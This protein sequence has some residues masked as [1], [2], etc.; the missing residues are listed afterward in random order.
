MDVSL[1]IISANVTEIPYME[2]LKIVASAMFGFCHFIRQYWS[3]MLPC[4]L[5]K[6]L[7]QVQCSNYTILS[8][9]ICPQK[10]TLFKIF[11]MI[12]TSHFFTHFLYHSSA[13]V[14]SNSAASTSICIFCNNRGFLSL[15]IAIAPPSVAK[16]VAWKV[17]HLP[18][19][20]P[21]RFNAPSIYSRCGNS[22]RCVYIQAVGGSYLWCALVWGVYRNLALM[23][24]T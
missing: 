12:A 23:A 3:C 6:L 10:L 14:F 20:S 4:V 8:H 16:T 13:S 7:V 2:V 9:D 24:K 1:V 17:L 15:C 18:D 11:H 22:A 21:Y 5:D 19:T